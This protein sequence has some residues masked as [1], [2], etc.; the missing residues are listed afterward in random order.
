M[1]V[2]RIEALLHKWHEETHHSVRGTYCCKPTRKGWNETQAHLVSLVIVSQWDMSWAVH[3]LCIHNVGKCCQ[4]LIPFPDVDLHV[5]GHLGGAG[6]KRLPVKRNSYR[7]TIFSIAW[8]ISQHSP[9]E[10][11]KCNWYV[12]KRGFVG[13][14]EAAHGTDNRTTAAFMLER[15]S[16]R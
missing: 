8:W 14:L 16:T 11:N 3:F 10:Q 12:L 6:I 13:W 2:W 1:A 4:W 15:W 9:K 7:T 5:M